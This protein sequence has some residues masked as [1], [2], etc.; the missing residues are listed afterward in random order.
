M[1]NK[2]NMVKNIINHNKEEIAFLIGNGINHHFKTSKSWNDVLIELWKNFS[3]STMSNIPPGVSLTEV[4]DLLEIENTNNG[5]RDFHIQKKVKDIFS[6]VNTNMNQNIILDKISSINAPLLTTNFDDLIKRSLDLEDYRLKK[7]KFTDF[8]PWGS[9]FSKKELDLPTD[10]FGVWHINGMV[11]YHR[12][13]KLGLSQYMGN[14]DRARKWIHGNKED[15]LFTGKNKI[16]WPG[17]YSWLHIIFNRSIFIVGLGL[18]EN[19]V[20]LRWLLIERA[21]YFRQFPDRVKSGWY[22]QQSN[23]GNIGRK[24]FLEKVGFEVID[25]DTY[26]DIY[27]EIW[28]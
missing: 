23:S 2:V 20:F 5:K 16:D 7:N 28:K 22:I 3:F 19:E 1:L 26:N 17:L 9:Y 25:L 12:S 14:V 8:Y 24:F 11:K 6:S 15:I 18:E 13:I 21:K 27:E 4:Y 10:G